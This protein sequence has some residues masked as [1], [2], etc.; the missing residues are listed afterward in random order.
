MA[1]PFKVR[2]PYCTHFTDM[3]PT[4]RVCVVAC[5]TPPHF[6]SQNLDDSPPQKLEQISKTVEDSHII[7]IWY[8]VSS[9]VTEETEID[10]VRKV[11]HAFR[12]VFYCEVKSTV[13]H[14]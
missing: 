4:K 2:V 10:I 13:V 7:T 5:F 3:H 8:L 14:M 1:K 12:L 6:H 9:F 11:D